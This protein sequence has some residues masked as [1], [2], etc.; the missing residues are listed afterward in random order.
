MRVDSSAF[1]ITQVKNRMI[2]RKPSPRTARSVQS[3][4]LPHGGM[5]PHTFVDSV[6]A[7]V[8]VAAVHVAIAEYVLGQL[9]VVLSI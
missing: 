3:Q 5:Q 4:L 8:R 9:P 1:R 7:V 6:R 2:S